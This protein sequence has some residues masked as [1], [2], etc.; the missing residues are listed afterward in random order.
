[1][2]GICGIAAP[3]G[4]GRRLDNALLE[5]M[6][7]E[8]VHRGP[9]ASGLFLEEGIG[10]GHRRLSIMDV[11]HGA[12]PMSSADGR[13]T[14]VY[15]GEV[16]NHLS[17]MPRL[18]AEGVR[19]STHCDTETLL[20][21]YE[22]HGDDTP[23]HLRGMFAFAI[24]DRD[25]RSLFIA[26]DRLGVKPLYYVYTDDGTLFFASE[27]KA[28]LA[29]GAVTP[30]LNR[31]AFPDYLANHAPSGEDT[32]FVGVKRLLPGHTLTWDNG[33]IAIRSYW[34]LS[35]A[36]PVDRRASICASAASPCS[37]SAA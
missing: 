3:A 18:Q 34:D 22:R 10:L 15:N 31:R 21:L 25:K 1:M 35:F 12:Q 37:T 33:R 8:M 30:A 14:V 26:R 9:D 36:Q 6:R 27:I 19:Y 29:A 13:Y 24:W 32:L 28:L 5:R 4:S 17:L 23:N 20:H 7:D 2:C 16:Y 11:A